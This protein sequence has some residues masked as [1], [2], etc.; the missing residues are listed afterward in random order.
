MK[1]RGLQRI[2]LWALLATTANCGSDQPLGPNGLP[3][4]VTDPT[5]DPQVISTYPADGSTGP[6]GLAGSN[7]DYGPHF[8]VELNKVVSIADVRAN[9]FRFEGFDGPVAAQLGSGIAPTPAFPWITVV[10]IVLRAGAYQVGRTYTVIVDTTLVDYT[11]RHLRHPVRF[12]YTPEPWFRVRHI[13]TLP[14][15]GAGILDPD[16]QIEVQFNSDVD[17]T[18]VSSLRLAPPVRG[19]WVTPGSGYARFLPAESF[20]LGRAYTLAIAPTAADRTGHH[21]RSTFEQRFN[22]VQF[23]VTL[24]FPGDGQLEVPER[25]SIQIAS[26]LDVDAASVAAAIRIEPPLPTS[27]HVERRWISTPPV[28]FQ[29][30]TRYEVTV[31]TALRTASGVPLPHPYTFTFTTDQFRLAGTYPRDGE[32]LAPPQN[33]FSVYFNARVDP[34]T[35]Q[36]GITISPPVAGLLTTEETSVRFWPNPALAAATVYTVTISQDLH[37]RSGEPLT[38]P[39]HFSFRTSRH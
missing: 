27:W 3:A 1:P 6:F 25:W 15:A 20:A 12:S 29:L 18:I 26:S 36:A 7:A 24:A 22:T 4:G 5:I 38:A 31:S 33:G 16:A 17:S 13:R 2:V 19:T 14:D 11:G 9:W 10:P 28:Y 32:S 39:Y 8:V 37:A 23:T 35:L 30:D 34:A 21:L